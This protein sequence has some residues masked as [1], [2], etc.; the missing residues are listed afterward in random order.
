MGDWGLDRDVWDFRTAF[1]PESFQTGAL[2]ESWEQPD[3]LTYIFHIRKG[4]NWH[5]KAP[6]NGRELTAKDVE[7]NFHRMTG[8]GSGYTEPSEF[9]INLQNVP[10]ESV[11]ATDKYTVVMKLEGAIPGCAGDPHRRSPHVYIPPR[12]N[13]GT[14]GR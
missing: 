9:R 12:G 8:L 3:P 5:D 2:A 11:T 7:F 6:M 13:R 1:T 10:F 14:R 4:V